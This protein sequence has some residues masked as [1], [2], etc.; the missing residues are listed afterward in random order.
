MTAKVSTVFVGTSARFVN[1]DSVPKTELLFAGRKSLLTEIPEWDKIDAEL[2]K[3]LPVGSAL[4]IARS[5]NKSVTQI[6]TSIRRYIKHNN[7]NYRVVA[8]EKLDKEHIFVKTAEA[9]PKIPVQARQSFRR[10][11]SDQPNHRYQNN[12]NQETRVA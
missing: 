10:R 1:L 8:S 12:Q 2:K 4:Q 11:V 7:L 3:G 5:P 9:K 6:A